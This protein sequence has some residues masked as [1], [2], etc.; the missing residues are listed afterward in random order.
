MIG[1]GPGD[2]VERP[3]HAHDGAQADVGGVFG[4]DVVQGLPQLPGALHPAVQVEDRG[5]H[6]GD[7]ALHVVDHVRQAPADLRRPGAGVGALQVQ[8]VGEQPLNDVIVQVPRDA[9]PVGEH[10]QR[11]EPSLVV[12]QLQRERRLIGEG[13]GE[14]E[15]TVVE[16]LPPRIANDRQHPRNGVG[17]RAQ[18]QQQRRP[19][20]VAVTVELR[21]LQRLTAPVHGSGRGPFDPDPLAPEPGRVRTGVCGDDQGRD[22]LR[23]HVGILGLGDLHVVRLRQGQRA[24]GDQAEHLLRVG[25]GE[26]LGA[27]LARGLLPALPQPGLLEQARIVHRDAR[28]GREGLH[29]HLVVLGER[30]TIGLLGEVEVAERLTVHPDRDTQEGPHGRVVG[31]EAGRGH[32]LGQIV[33]ADRFRLFDQQSEQ[34]VAGGEV[35]DQRAGVCVYALV[36]EVLQSVPAAVEDAQGAVAAVHEL[37]R[38]VHDALERRL[39]LEPGRD[40]EHG[41]EQTVDLIAR[42]DHLVD[43]VLDLREQFP[44]SQ[45]RERPREQRFLVGGHRSPLR[46]ITSRTPRAGPLRKA[47]FF[48]LCRG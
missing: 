18:R 46:W 34:S 33:E 9:V 10:G 44:Q 39:E 1:E 13:G 14:E 15:L 3:G 30:L 7:D 26:Q 38:G 36:H 42:D 6:V 31:R 35:A 17:R 24:S 8:A 29:D 16:R 19:V 12:G 25:V 43:A 40:R 32:V 23:R 37:D 11:V 41:L 22:L 28:R 21:D 4:D 47:R 45:L 48:P 27:D 2:H 5:A 20:P